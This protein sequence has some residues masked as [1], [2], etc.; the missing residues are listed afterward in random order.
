MN[1]STSTTPPT[2]NRLAADRARFAQLG[3]NHTVPDCPAE[4]FKEQANQGAGRLLRCRSCGRYVRL[5]PLDPPP[6]A[7]TGDRAQ[8]ASDLPPAAPASDPREVVQEQKPR[9]RGN[10]R[11][12]AHLNN[13]TTWRG[14]GC[15][16]CEAAQ[17]ARVR[18]RAALA[19]QRRARNADEE[20]RA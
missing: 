20:S 8:V 18:A 11:C 13:A 10:Y 9:P 3:G 19:R 1:P 17:R 7:P 6:P 14:R 15:V 4:S 16:D 5:D 2:T 12:P